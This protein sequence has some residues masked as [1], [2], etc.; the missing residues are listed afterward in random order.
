MDDD[1]DDDDRNA[2]PSVDVAAGNDTINFV[3]YE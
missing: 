3:L 2:G 1:D